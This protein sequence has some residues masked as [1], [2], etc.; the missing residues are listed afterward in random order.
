ML[1][2]EQIQNLKEGDPLIIHGTYKGKHSDGDLRITSTM[3]VGDSLE[4]SI[5]TVH[6][7]CVSLPSEIV[8]SQSSI[9]NKHDPTRLFKKGDKVRVVEWNGRKDCRNG[10][11]ATVL[12]NERGCFVDIE[13]MIKEVKAELTYPACHLDLITPV[14]EMEPYSV[15]ESDAFDIVRE[16]KIVMTIPFTEDDYYTFEQAQAAAKAE[17][18]RLNAEWRKERE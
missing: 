12:S 7:S 9:V 3:T 5:K 14:E 10:M 11:E 17:R 6:P 2:Q 16:G 1:T 15:R 13:C 18:D 4:D 8:N